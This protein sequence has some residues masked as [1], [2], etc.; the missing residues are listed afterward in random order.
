MLYF[1]NL[2]WIFFL[3]ILLLIILDDDI[4]DDDEVGCGF[5]ILIF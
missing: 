4:G 1:R 3:C 2:G 5:L